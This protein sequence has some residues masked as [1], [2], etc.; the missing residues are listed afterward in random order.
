MLRLSGSDDGGDGDDDGSNSVH[1]GGRGGRVGGRV[2]MMEKLAVAVVVAVPVMKT[3]PCGCQPRL[4][5]L[6][7]AQNQLPH[8]PPSPAQTWQAGTWNMDKA[9]WPQALPPRRKQKAPTHGQ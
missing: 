2:T 9:F 6:R 3:I 8:R 1:G 5:Q 7:R 4:G